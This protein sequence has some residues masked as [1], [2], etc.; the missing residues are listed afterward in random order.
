MTPLRTVYGLV[1]LL[2]SV[3]V[4]GQDT[5]SVVYAAPDKLDSYWTAVVKNAPKYPR[6]AMRSNLQGC[7][8][9]SYVI[10]H[11][12][13]TSSHTPLAMMPSDAFTKAAIKAAKTFRYA[14]G[15]Q[16][17]DGNPV[18]TFTTFTFFLGADRK[19]QEARQAQLDTACT[20]AAIER[21][22]ELSQP[23]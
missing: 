6:R 20:D 7:V 16:N 19:E 15:N 3:S 9:V 14:P 4:S 11:D 12:G 2:V 21:I 18:L 17:P 13:R 10:E 1:F 23:E 5:Q 22:A 8:A